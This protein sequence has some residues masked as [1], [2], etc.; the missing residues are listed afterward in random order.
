MITLRGVVIVH[1]FQGAGKTLFLTKYAFDK[2]ELY[3]N[4][5]SNYKLK[6]IKYEELDI[7]DMFINKQEITNSLILIDE[8]HLFFQARQSMSAFNRLITWFFTQTRKRGNTV[9]ITTIPKM[10]DINLRYRS[11]FFHAFPKPLAPSYYM[12]IIK[13]YYE[14]K[15]CRKLE[16]L[17]SFNY[18]LKQIQKCYTE[19][20]TTTHL[21][22]DENQNILMPINP[23]Y[24]V[25]YNLP[26][27]YFQVDFYS[28]PPE[29][30]PFHQIA[31]NG[32]KYYNYYDTTEL[33][34]P[35]WDKLKQWEKTQKRSKNAR[36]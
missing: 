36:R 27:E 9:L 33:I 1:G 14:L 21:D 34:M 10:L 22:E 31:Y 23:A 24:V 32:S 20:I 13:Y 12:S 25:T 5:Y 19:L 29:N 35:D 16:R 18:Q 3:E 15:A 4:V 11:A 2:N 30:K 7:I 17:K 28:N 26:V 8:G 6:K